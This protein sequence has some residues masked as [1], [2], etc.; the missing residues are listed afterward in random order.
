MTNDRPTDRRLAA[1]QAVRLLLL[2]GF[3]AGARNPSAPL[4]FF[5][6]PQIFNLLV[7]P[8]ACQAALS[9][10]LCPRDN[11]PPIACVCGLVER[12]REPR[13]TE[14]LENCDCLTSS[15]S[16]STLFIANLILHPF[17]PSHHILPSSS[18]HNIT[19][20]HS[21]GPCSYTH[22]RH[23]FAPRSS[24]WMHR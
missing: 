2:A 23:P 15:C 5:P 6:L 20:D 18:R 19:Q 16:I 11:S 8:P 12:E 4:D 17:T 3:D 1:R 21:R 14:T 13:P 9:S 22:T 10:C 7:R 24:S